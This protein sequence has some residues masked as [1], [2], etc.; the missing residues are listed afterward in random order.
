MANTNNNG[1]DGKSQNRSYYVGT[2]WKKTFWKIIC[3]YWL[4]FITCI[5]KDQAI[6]FYLF[7]YFFGGAGFV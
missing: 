2:F 4:N 5:S 7:V 3:Q 1:E 6:H